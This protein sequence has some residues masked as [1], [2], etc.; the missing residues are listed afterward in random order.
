MSR[1]NT[2]ATRCKSSSKQCKSISPRTSV[3]DRLGPPG[4][5]SQPMKNEETCRYILK[6][7][8]CRFGNECTYDHGP[9]ISVTHALLPG[10]VTRISSNSFD[11]D[12]ILLNANKSEG[13]FQDGKISVNSNCEKKISE[14]DQIK[15]NIRRHISG[16][17]KVNNLDD[18]DTP[19]T[20]NL[21]GLKH[22]GSVV[23]RGCK[24]TIQVTQLD[25]NSNVQD[26]LFFNPLNPTSILQNPSFD[27]ET[28]LTSESFVSGD[29]KDS[30]TDSM[31]G[32]ETLVLEMTSSKD[33]RDKALS[34][35]SE[36]SF[37]SVPSNDKIA[38]GR[39]N[40]E[41][42]STSRVSKDQRERALD[43][44]GGKNNRANVTK[45][46]NN[47]L[48]IA[49]KRS[50]VLSPRPLRSSS[51]KYLKK[52]YKRIKSISDEFNKYKKDHHRDKKRLSRSNQGIYSLMC[53]HYVTKT[54]F[55]CLCVS[56]V[57]MNIH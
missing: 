5:I 42:H 38:T 31:S 30:S 17:S 36:S 28:S 37:S 7:G 23:Q 50:D 41:L 18:K 35:I 15:D 27:K 49:P 52:H 6:N 34:S 40:R 57:A 3:Y 11:G 39:K 25:V 22:M 26:N 12:S 1:R 19:I 55:V 10:E 9:S 20:K 29:D 24:S 2:D 53:C 45:Y 47:C 46:D 4:L 56:S 32:N 48:K 51:H 13:L 8:H 43:F 14:M 44:V 33:F 54:Q 16:T 21:R